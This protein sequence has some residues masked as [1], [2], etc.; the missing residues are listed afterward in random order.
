MRSIAEEWE[1][2]RKTVVPGDAGEGQARDME[3]SFYAGAMVV[4]NQLLNVPDGEV[5]EAKEEEYVEHLKTIGD[6][7]DTFS[8]KKTAEAKAM[9]GAG[10]VSGGVH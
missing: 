4:F 7:L 5:T 1:V 2:F 9:M 3:M 10:G 8:E 6:E